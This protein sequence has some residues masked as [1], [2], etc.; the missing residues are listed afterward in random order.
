[1]IK[2]KG[3]SPGI[4]YRIMWRF[5][6]RKRWLIARDAEARN[7]REAEKLLL[8]YK[9]ATWNAKGKEFKIDKCR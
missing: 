8:K 9:K 7:K 5:K 2:R 6:K 1:M 3:C 4:K